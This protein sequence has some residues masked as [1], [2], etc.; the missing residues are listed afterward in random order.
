MKL[1]SSQLVLTILGIGLVLRL[2]IAAL[3]PPGFDE[4]YYFLYTLNLDWSYFD[5][6]PLVALTTGLGI[7]LWGGYI[8]QLTIRFIP[9]LLYT[10]T[11]YG[12]YRCGQR[13]FSTRVGLLAM[14][15]ATIAPIF[16]VAF[17]AMTLPDAP[18]MFFWVTSLY[19]ASCEFFPPHD[20]AYRPTRRLAILGVLIGLACLG[21]YHGFFLGAGLVG[22]CLTSAPHRKALFS[23]WT[24]VALG[25]FG[26]TIFPMLYWNHLHEW[27]SFTFQA[28]RGLPKQFAW[29]RFGKAFITEMLFLFPTIGFPLVFVSLQR[30]AQQFLGSQ[31]D[32]TLQQKRRLVMW[33]SLPV[34]IGFTVIGGYR[35]IF[36][37]WA[38][39]GFFTATLLL[40][41]VAATLRSRVIK[42]WLG[43]TVIV[44][45]AILAISL[46]HVVWGTLQYPSQNQIVG[47]LPAQ[48]REDGSIEL[49][50][51]VQLRQGFAKTPALM[52][53]LTQTDFVFT[54]RFHLS[55]HVGMALTNLARKP[56]T[57]FDRRDMRGFA[58][59]SSADQWVG[60]TGLYL[61]T[62]RFQTE[63][64]SAAEYLPYFQQ[65]TEVGSVPLYRGGIEIDR[66]HVFQGKNLLRSFPRPIRATQGA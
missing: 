53:A 48:A 47:L 42:L 46:S 33:V 15:I 45:Q 22:F 25:L 49:I 35:Q 59:W 9:V 12:L 3:L 24:I 10:A 61:T 19:V 54:N 55:G 57:C 13:L 41:E 5:H 23:R 4:A 38:M 36:P 43:I 31:K 39:P 26:L 16:Q 40:A 30:F 52:Q 34:M 7:T 8:S 21:K 32:I 29:D 65:L 64:N 50:D 63:E 56:I 20:R 44:V 2:L 6:P 62:D 18:L 27:A 58:F 28:E 11:L 51:V 66:I 60:Q 1:L 37:T 17:G 14:T